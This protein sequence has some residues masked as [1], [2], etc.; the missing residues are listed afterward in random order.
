[1][2]IVDKVS[3]GLLWIGIGWWVLALALTAVREGVERVRIVRWSRVAQAFA[4]LALLLH[5]LLLRDITVGCLALL[6]I[7]VAMRAVRNAVAALPVEV[8]MPHGAP[9]LRRGKR[10]ELRV[11]RGGAA[12]GSAPRAGAR[13]P[14]VRPNA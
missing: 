9:L 1:V 8:A 14:H 6:W 4:G 12:R 10:P 2:S 7:V 5:A 3:D 11:I 13:T